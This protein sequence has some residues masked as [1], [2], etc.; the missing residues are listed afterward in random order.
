MAEISDFFHIILIVLSHEYIEVVVSRT[1][2]NFIPVGDGAASDRP[3]SLKAP[4]ELA[5]YLVK[6]IKGSINRAKVY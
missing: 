2:K 5:I 1:D 3:L 6:A 4:F